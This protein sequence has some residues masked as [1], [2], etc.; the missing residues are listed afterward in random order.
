[1][2]GFGRHA[3]TLPPT[4]PRNYFIVSC[5]RSRSYVFSRLLNFSK[6]LYVLLLARIISETIIKIGI[7]LFYWRLFPSKYIRSSVWLVGTF[8]LVCF[9][10]GFIGFVL[11]CVP[12][13]GFWNPSI[14]ATCVHEIQFFDAIASLGLIGDIILLVQPLPVIVRLKV[15]AQTRL[16]L[17]L[18]FLN[19]GV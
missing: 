3:D 14:H 5:S 10:T 4:Y 15:S 13:K 12:V 16:G 6:C 1:M 17:A 11:Q 18:V 8:F 2:Y 19:G 9:V 7:L